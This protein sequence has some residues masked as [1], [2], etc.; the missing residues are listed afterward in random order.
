M[1]KPPARR[2]LLKLSGEA[3]AGGKQD[4][5]FDQDVLNY[6]ATQVQRLGGAGIEVAIVL[7][8]G[9]LFR[10]AEMVLEG[11][12]RL[13][14]DYMGMLGT[15]INALAM[16]DVL[17]SFGVEAGIYTPFLMP[18]F[19]DRFNATKVSKAMQKGQVAVLAGGTGNPYCTTDSAAALRGAEL[20]VD[21]LLK[22]TKVDGVYDSDP[23]RNRDAIR[24]DRLTYREVLEKGLRVMD[25]GAIALCE[26][27][28][29]PIRVFKFSD[30]SSFERLASGDGQVGTLITTEEAR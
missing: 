18:A 4:R 13:S 30:P 17:T 20:Q 15:I 27:A 10:G 16:Q 2:I 12:S 29:L 5:T 14:G 8:G 19:A 11:V 6:L 1:G 26:E 9:N 7:G 3:L 22:A 24:F 21:V 25:H 23:V 28:G